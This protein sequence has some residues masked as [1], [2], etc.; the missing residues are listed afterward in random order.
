MPE[1]TDKKQKKNPEHWFKPGESGNPNGRPKGAVNFATKWRN[2]IDKLAK[3]KGMTGDEL[4]LEILQTGLLKAQE[5]DFS[6]YRDT[7]DRVYGKPQQSVD[8]TTN[9]ESVKPEPTKKED[10]KAVGEFHEQ[11]KENLRKRAEDEE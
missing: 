5:G 4:E 7:F 1:N 2:A 11:L 3:T 6:F 8:V 9:G 10:T